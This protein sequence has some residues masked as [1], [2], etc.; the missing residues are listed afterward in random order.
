[1]IWMLTATRR[2]IQSGKI[3][4]F[5]SLENKIRVNP[6]EKKKPG[7]TASHHFGILKVS[8][9]QIGYFSEIDTGLLPN[10]GLFIG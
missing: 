6:T 8:N 5:L 3:K 9:S 1:M 7:G 10:M 2:V 4:D